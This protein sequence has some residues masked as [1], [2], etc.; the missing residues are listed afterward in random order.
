MLTLLAGVTSA[1]G[2]IT[3]DDPAYSVSTVFNGANSADDL[4]SYDWSGGNLYYAESSPGDTFD[5]LYENNSPTP[6]V[7]ANSDFSGASVVSIGNYVYYNDSDNANENI[8]AYNT[9]TGTAALASTATNYG[10]YA[11]TGSLFITGAPGFGTNHIYETGLNSNGTFTLNPPADLGA[12]SGSS[13]PLAFDAAGNLYYAPGYGDTSIYKFTAAQV[14]A[15]LADPTGHPLSITPANVWATYGS[16]Y[17]QSG[18]TSMIVLGNQL[19]LTLTTFD[20]PSQ[21]VTFGIGSNGSYNSSTNSILTSSDLL[22]ELRENNGNLDVSD[23][24]SIVQVTAPEPATWCLLGLGLATVALWR[25]RRGAATVALVV[26]AA[27]FSGL[28]AVAGPFSPDGDE[29]GSNGV[30][31]S[32]SGITE[33]ASGVVS[34]DPG[35]DDVL[36]PNSP[37]PTYNNTAN[38]LG[39]AD[40]TASN[41]YPVVSLGE[42]G[43]ITLSFNTPIANGPGADFAVFTNKFN[44]TPNNYFLELATVSVSSDGV[45][46]F[47]FPSVSLTPTTTQVGAFGTIDPTNLFNLAGSEIAGYGTPFDLS[48]L[49]GVSP[50][51]N[52]NDIT[53]LRLDDVIGNV[54][55]ALGPVSYDDA[56][57]PLFGGAYGTTNHIINAPFPTDYPSSGFSLDAIGVI[58]T[59]TT[60]PEPPTWVMMFA[61]LLCGGLIIRFRPRRI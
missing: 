11:G 55:P 5:G 15:A 41:P 2:D 22:G 8:F 26:L 61:G 23:G 57:N 19:F 14:A 3:V 60:S 33:W 35:P 50:L 44:V 25:K 24:D 38:A 46:F 49:A 45:N 31:S 39:P 37:V 13:G 32:S 48:E 10:L 27:S 53:E 42:G 56:S 36:I 6:V 40:A 28:R 43:S 58:N 16:T 12:D 17:Q 29:P 47:T 51:L 1:P 21:L 54:N 7:A 4:Y 52:I 59:A 34:Y 20:A 18:A 30:A 9:G